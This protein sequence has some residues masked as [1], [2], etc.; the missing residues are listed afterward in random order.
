MPF[1]T[2]RIPNNNYF[3]MVRL[4]ISNSLSTNSLSLNS[5]K[6]G[7]SSSWYSSSSGSWYSSTADEFSFNSLSTNTLKSYYD[8][9]KINNGV[10]ML[11]LEEK[12]RQKVRKIMGGSDGI[13][14][15]CRPIR[16]CHY[17]WHPDWSIPIRYPILE[18]QIV[19]FELISNPNFY[20]G[21]MLCVFINI[22]LLIMPTMPSNT[23]HNFRR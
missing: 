10:N 23:G 21:V 4:K 3:R 17:V 7:S 22:L 2:T 18:Y 6:R 13:S 14:N 11:K 20:N 16:T 9:A 19:A 8:L 15:S 1:P 5:I 12:Q